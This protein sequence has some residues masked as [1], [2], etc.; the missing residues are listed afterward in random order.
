V[1]AILE[2][3]VL[4][5]AGSSKKALVLKA[6]NKRAHASKREA[7]GARK[8]SKPARKGQIKA[9]ASKGKA[10]APKGRKRIRQQKSI[11]EDDSEEEESWPC[12]I[13]GETYSRSREQWVQCQECKHW[14]HED[15]TDGSYYFIC[16]N[17]ESDDDLR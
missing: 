5:N 11:S 4:K 2:A 6:E 3:K 7:G 12:V 17:C 1:K 9:A 10:P 15:C 8:L 13:C 16:P 14:A